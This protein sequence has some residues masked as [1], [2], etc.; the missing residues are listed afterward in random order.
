MN[1][2]VPVKKTWTDKFL[3]GVERIGNALPHPATLFALLA[4]L[5]I[6]LSGIISLFNVSVAHPGTGETV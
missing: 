6:V 1:T 2:G 5:V 3:S 4:L